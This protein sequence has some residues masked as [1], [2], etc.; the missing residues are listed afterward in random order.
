[1]GLEQQIISIHNV[2]VVRE[3]KGT[4]NTLVTKL[5]PIVENPRNLLLQC[6]AVVAMVIVVVAVVA[7]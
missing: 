5:K 4:R 3:V 1:M 6:L 2:I 7:E